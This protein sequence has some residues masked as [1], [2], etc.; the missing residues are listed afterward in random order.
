MKEMAIRLRKID[1]RIFSHHQEHQSRTWLA[2]V[3]ASQGIMA[4]TS[5]SS[6]QIAVREAIF[7]SDPI[8][9]IQ[10]LLSVPKPKKTSDIGFLIT[11]RPRVTGLGLQ[12]MPALS[13]GQTLKVTPVK[14]TQKLKDT[15]QRL[16]TGINSVNFPLH[17]NHLQ[18]KFHKA[19]G[20][21]LP[22]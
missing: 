21:G 13:K 3:Q 18:E 5:M 10:E 22:G 7:L 17:R 1:L 15:R 8:A 4:K 2:I 19:G 6:P 11:W 16:T 9:R 20:Q 12:H 14:N